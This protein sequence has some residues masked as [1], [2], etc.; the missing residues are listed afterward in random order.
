M[1]PPD[2]SSCGRRSSTGDVLEHAHQV[3]F[4]LVVTANGVVTAGPRWRAQAYDRAAHRKVRW[5]TESVKARGA[6]A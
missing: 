3:D 4:M 6:D 1:I 2:Q 5:S